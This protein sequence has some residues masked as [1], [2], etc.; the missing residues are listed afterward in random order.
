ADLLLQALTLRGT[1]NPDKAVARVRAGQALEVPAEDAL[2]MDDLDLAAAVPEVK[3]SD[4][5]PEVD[6]FVYPEKETPTVPDRPPAEMLIEPP[7]TQVALPDP[8]ITG[9]DDD[10]I[11]LEVAEIDL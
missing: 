11:M 5:L 10:T 8:P 1:P 6:I 7:A 3:A 2:S 4:A 9:D